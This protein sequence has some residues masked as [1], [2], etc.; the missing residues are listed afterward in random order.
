M[1]D[2]HYAWSYS[3][4]NQFITCP[5][6]YEASRVTKTLPYTETD[7]IKYGKD[8]H[9]AAE[10]YISQGT[11]LPKPFEFI[12]SY[13]DMLNNIKGTKH[14]ELKLGLA[15]RDGKFVACDFFAT[16]VYFR[17]V[18]DLVIIDGERAFVVDY[19]TGKNAEYADDKQLGL[20][21]A[22]IFARFPSVKKIK[23]MLLFVIAK[24]IVKTEYNN[25]QKYDIFVKL[26]EDLMRRE[27]A[28]STGVFNPRQNG[29]CRNYCGV[30]AC[31]HNGAYNG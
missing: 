24:Q 20:L 18:A 14:C 25:E 8:L 17:G 4:I 28:H 31:Q 30:T 11:P 2:S 21:A 12:K 6:L 7:V 1:P 27:T 3:S 10:L 16:D 5:K 13:L 29:L 22:A 23:G 19:K 15:I 26:S 9:S